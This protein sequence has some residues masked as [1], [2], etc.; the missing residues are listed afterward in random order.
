MMTIVIEGIDITPDEMA[1]SAFGRS[2]NTAK[3]H[4]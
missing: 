3:K 4:C 2:S 1:D